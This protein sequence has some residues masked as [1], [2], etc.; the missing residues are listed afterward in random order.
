MDEKQL[1]A[2]V[3]ALK[4]AIGKLERTGSNKD[5]QKKREFLVNLVSSI[6]LPLTIALSGYWFSQAIKTQELKA[7]AREARARD[8]LENIHYQEQLKLSLQSQRLENYKF[9]TPLLEIL[10]SPD[11]KRR[12]YATSVILEIM[13]EEGPQLLNIAKSSDPANSAEYEKTLVS[14]Q[15]ILVANLFADDA[16]VRTSSA[17]DIMVNWYKT[18]DIVQVL[19]DYANAHLENANGIF[20][21]VVVLQNMSG[22]VLKVNKPKIQQFLQTVMRMKNMDKTIT[23]ATALNN[24]I[25]KL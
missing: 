18:S 14:K 11:P 21:T 23:N 20:N 17:N 19:L 3:E 1:T 8:S 16:S 25:G 6:L 13:P 12:T 15:A 22:R 24:A 9:I 10:L 7:N 2:E 5:P 4:E